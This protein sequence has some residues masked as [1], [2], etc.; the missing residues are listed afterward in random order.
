MGLTGVVLLAAC[1]TDD[2][3]TSNGKISVVASFYPLAEF[4]RQVGGNLVSVSTVT[5]AGAEPHEYEPTT[6][7]LINLQKAD[8]FIFMGGGFD[9]WAEKVSVDAPSSDHDC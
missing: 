3:P 9:P 5:P 4:S 1:E 8:L 6:R 7:D 2:V